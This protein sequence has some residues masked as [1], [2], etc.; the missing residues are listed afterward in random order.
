MAGEGDRLSPLNAI[1]GALP[2][3]ALVTVY[4]V[5]ATPG[6]GPDATRGVLAV[7]QRLAGRGNTLT[8]IV[9]ANPDDLRSDLRPQIGWWAPGQQQIVYGLRVTGASLDASLRTA[10]TLSWATGI[11]AWGLLF[12][13]SLGNTRVVAW[14]LAA[15]ALFRASHAGAFQYSGG[16]TLLWAAFP[17][18]AL[19][20]LWALGIRGSTQIPGAVAAG[21]LAGVLVWLKYSGGVLG[22]GLGLTWLWS[23][24]RRNLAIRAVIAW[25][26]GGLL[27]TLIVALVGVLALMQGRTPAT[28]LTSYPPAVVLAVGVV[29]PLAGLSDALDVLAFA[30]RRFNWGPPSDAAV[31]MLMLAL[32]GLFSSWAIARVR[33]GESFASERSPAHVMAFRQA[34]SVAVTV[35]VVLIVIQLRGGILNWEIRYHQYGAFLLMPFLAEALAASVRSTRRHLRW[36]TVACLAVFFGLPALYGGS[37]LSARSVRTALRSTSIDAQGWLPD[38]RPSAAVIEELQALPRF[39]TAV[40]AT[41]S[42]PAALAFPAQRLQFLMQS[43]HWRSE[44]FAGR[45]PGGVALI[46]PPGIRQA[47]A[48]VL[49]DAFLDIHVWTRV[50]LLSAPATQVWFGS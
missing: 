16:E 27:A 50:S 43:G 35:S 30:A 49:Q 32:A 25:G 11:T 1:R 28:P 33:Q 31:G 18:V 26:A 40:L 10:V 5:T 23:W 13:R 34:V 6:I 41:P 45:P 9:I 2:V 4:V 19:L 39:R 22:L 8:E 17:V 46:L 47:D 20:N 48:R 37:L 21:L 7:E 14:L 36:G 42:I 15:F 3:V 38:G 24:L 44:R 29:G 12:W